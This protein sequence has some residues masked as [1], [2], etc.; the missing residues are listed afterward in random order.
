MLLL[1]AKI[2]TLSRP[3]TGR[4]YSRQILTLYIV[5]EE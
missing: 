1:A 5:Q 2:N 3:G 4:C